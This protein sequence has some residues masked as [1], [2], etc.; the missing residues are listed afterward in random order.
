M[1]PFAPPP[2]PPSPRRTVRPSSD[3]PLVY[4]TSSHDKSRSFVS[5]GAKPIRRLDFIQQ[6]AQGKLEATSP[7][8]RVVNHGEVF[9]I[10]RPVSILHILEHL[11]GSASRERNPSEGAASNEEA[12][13]IVQRDGHLSG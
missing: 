10:R 1:D 5:P 3:M 6:L 8:I 9:A 11:A 4:V 12:R 2:K 13:P 7:I